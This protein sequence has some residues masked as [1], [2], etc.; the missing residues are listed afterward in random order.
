MNAVAKIAVVTGAG[1]GIG[2]S[3]A[4]TL[5]QAGWSVILAGRRAE[6]LEETASLA[7]G[8]VLCV[9]TDVTS[10]ADV[11]TLFATVRERHGR[12]GLLFNNAGA[13]GP[14][15]PFEDISYEDWLAVVD[16]NLTGAFLC[17]QA[18][19]RMMKEQSP[20]GGRII[21]NGSISA[22]VPRPHSAPYTSTKHAMTGLTKSLSLDGRAYGIACGQIDIGNAATEM[23]RRMRAGILQ[24]SGEVVVEPVM[25]AGDVARTVRHMAELPLEANVQFATVM[26]TTMPYVGRG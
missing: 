26:A 21:N 23:T 3:V 19:F 5:A 14:R 8:D 10:P 7:G 22:H 17:A 24:A 4:V 15:V 2:R 16:V 11:T 1:S 25:D 6:T 18:A 13:S 12:V 20:Q 9:P